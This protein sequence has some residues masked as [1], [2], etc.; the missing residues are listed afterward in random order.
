MLSALSAFTEQNNTKTP[1]MLKTFSSILITCSALAPLTTAA[2]T[3]AAD[4]L[5]AA[6][7][8]PRNETDVH[9]HT[10]SNNS[11]STGNMWQ[12]AAK[13]IQYRATAQ[14]NA[15]DGMAPLWLTSNRYGLSS[16]DGSNGYLRVALERSV[17]RDSLSKWRL[18]YGADVAVAY[19][20]TSTAVVQQL[21][22]DFDYKLVRLTIGAKEQPMEFKNQE[23]SS[24][25]QTLGINARP[26]PQVRIGLPEYWN[27]SG[28][29]NWAAIKGHIGYGMMT[30]GR[31][32][33]DYLT[34]PGAQSRARFFSTQKR[35][36]CD[37]VTRR[38]SPSPLKVD[39]KWPVSL[40]APSITS[41]MPT[42]RNVHPKRCPTDFAISSTLLWALV[43][44]RAT[45]F[46]PMPRATQWVAGF[47]A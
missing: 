23:L 43:A 4:T 46:M 20:F 47:S 9:S 45:A 3:I 16:V 15:A 12:R 35:V 42:E 27:I 29:G 33:R 14:V 38:S 44:T 1:F 13:G 32:Q 31:F 28:R 34:S 41:P 26:I 39:W 36:I 7:S 21:Y 5:C 11:H 18:G 25:S 6:E 40:P 30:D 2:E 10:L 8:F 37:W 24:G 17:M 19:N 22:A